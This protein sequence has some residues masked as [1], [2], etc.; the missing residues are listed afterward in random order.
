MQFRCRACGCFWDRRYGEK[1]TFVWSE[2]VGL[3][4]GM[5][6]PGRPGTAPP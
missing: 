1:G 6:T 2:S 5:D 4:P 3:R